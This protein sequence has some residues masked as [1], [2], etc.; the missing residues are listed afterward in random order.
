MYCNP[1]NT[2]TLTYSIKL[3]VNEPLVPRE[4]PAVT[5]FHLLLRGGAWFSCANVEEERTKTAHTNYSKSSALH[6]ALSNQLT[7]G[8]TILLCYRC[9]CLVTHVWI[10]TSPTVTSVNYMYH[11]TDDL[12]VN[13]VL[14][15]A[16]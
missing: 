7:K 1:E 3:W 14:H 15:V 2:K 10:N 5:F 8:N 11:T 12:R 13:H 9:T 6:D 4:L 16:R